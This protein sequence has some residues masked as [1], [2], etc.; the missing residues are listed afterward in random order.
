MTADSSLSGGISLLEIKR[1]ETGTKSFHFPKRRK[2][3]EKDDE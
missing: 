3:D 1:R 2:T